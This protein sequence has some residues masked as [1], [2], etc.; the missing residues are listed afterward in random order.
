MTVTE[1][2][3]GQCLA[4]GLLPPERIVTLAGGADAEAYRPAPADPA[5]GAGGS[6]P[7]TAGPWSGMVA[8][9]RVMKGHRVVIE[10][11]GAARARRVVRPH[12]VFVGR[13]AHGA[14]AARGRRAG[15]GS[16]PR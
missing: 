13:G 6:A 9:L 7:R 16:R 12:V 3:R 2:I 8:G 10:A 4:A 14:G 5:S 1:A 15:P 11:A